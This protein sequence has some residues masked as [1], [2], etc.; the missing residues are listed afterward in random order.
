[1]IVIFL[2]ASLVFANSAPVQ[3]AQED[4]NPFLLFGIGGK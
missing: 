3:N 2:Y 1:M 4:K